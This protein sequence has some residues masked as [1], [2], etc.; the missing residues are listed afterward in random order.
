MRKILQQ[1]GYLYLLLIIPLF[2]IPFLQSSAL[3]DTSLHIRFLALN[4]WLLSLGFFLIVIR[5]NLSFRFNKLIIIYLCYI[6]YS[7]IS[8]FVS[9]NYADAAYQ[10]VM[11]CMLGILIFFYTIL[12]ANFP[13][14]IQYI[15][16]LFNGLA[17]VVLAHSLSDYFA[18][19]SSTGITHQTIYTIKASFSHK[20]ILSEVL[21]VLFPFALY[22]I[23]DENKWLKLLGS[24]NSIGI[25]FLIIILLTRAVWVALVLGFVLSFLLFVI[26]SGKK[27]LISLF[28]NKT[29]YLFI[30][31]FLLVIAASLFVYSRI[32]SLA[33]ITKSTHK[34]FKAYDSSQHRIE[35]WKRSIDITRESPILGKGLGTWRIEVLKYGNRNLKSEDNIT[36]YQR[37]HN[38]FLWILSEQGIIGL[39][40]YL[41]IIAFAFYYLIQILRTSSSSNEKV[42]FYLLFYLL[43][44]YQIFS[45]FSFPR[46]RIEHNLILGIILAFIVAKYQQLKDKAPPQTLAEKYMVFVF[47]GIC[48]FLISTTKMAYSRY[49]SEVHLRKAFEARSIGDWKTVIQEVNQSTSAFY[50][51]DPFSTPLIW[52]SGEAS[53]NSGNTELAF[54]DY[55]KSYAINPY[56]IYVLNNLATLY[57]L[58][59]EHTKAI[60]LYTKAIK[61]SPNFDDAL[62][63]LTAVYFNLGKID[64]ACN[65]ISSVDTLTK[66]EKYQNFLEAVLKKNIENKIN[67]IDNKLITD[68]LIKIKDYN[69]WMLSIFKKSRRNC[70]N[71]DKQLFIDCL[72]VL[73]YVDYSI[74][75]ATYNEL[76][77]KYI[78]N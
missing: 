38:D 26:I 40:F 41:A 11:I 54:E 12:F 34:I 21:L 60:D 6:F 73:R 16:L 18:I 51:L 9:A 2:V 3:L 1:Q 44:G 75:Q 72:F 22:L 47:I 5:K 71:F 23:F 45:F 70:I 33:T 59:G 49:N 24:V 25:L 46:E 55:K 10:F 8:V 76:K 65:I 37:P 56:H 32:D 52:Y 61:I 74:N 64:S 20:N 42:F 53:Y 69:A 68:E 14:K 7:L 50:Q 48:I 66:N 30:I 28:Q 77:I 57:E 29:T 17:I 19:L 78:E 27:K 4:I 13:F 39:A 63:N 31:T 36:F 67:T 35:L 62:I 58:K 15:A 43:M